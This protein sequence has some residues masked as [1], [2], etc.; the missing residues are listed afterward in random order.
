[1]WD[2]D[3]GICMEVSLV[4]FAK[5]RECMVVTVDGIV[6]EFIMH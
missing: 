2:T 1:M 6:N 3:A 5:A 4:Q